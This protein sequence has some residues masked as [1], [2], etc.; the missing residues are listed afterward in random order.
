MTTSNASN[1][2][3]FAC[4]PMLNHVVGNHCRG[5][6]VV[7]PLPLSSSLHW[8]DR[9]TLVLVLAAVL[10]LVL[11]GLWC[12]GYCRQA[13]AAGTVVLV[14]MLVVV[15]GAIVVVI[16]LGDGAMLVLAIIVIV[17]FVIVV[18]MLPRGCQID[19]ADTIFAK[20]SSMW[21]DTWIEMW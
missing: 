7:G 20:R 21:S 1:T 16:T 2:T 6:V 18:P 11:V 13:G 10:I 14:V 15:S 4:C 9:A 19:E 8:D 17:Q 3:T 5:V 12:W